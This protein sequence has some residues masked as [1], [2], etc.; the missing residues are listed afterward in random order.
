MQE[1]GLKEQSEEYPD[2]NKPPA[3]ELVRTRNENDNIKLDLLIHWDID[4]VT[5]ETEQGSEEAW[6]Y[7]EEKLYGVK[8][9]G[10]QS[11]VDDWLN[12]NEQFLMLK[13]KQRADDLTTEEKEQLID[14]ETGKVIDSKVH[15]ASG[16]EEQIGVLRY[17]ITEL[18]NRLGETV[19][20]ELD[21]LNSIANSEIDNGQDKKS[22]L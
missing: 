15:P 7:K 17:S 18:Y 11:E 22:D 3:I 19:P 6:Q 16:V 21:D 14:Y 5:R 1:R 8:Y 10:L 2:K 4:E 20:T 13:A 9:K 12:K